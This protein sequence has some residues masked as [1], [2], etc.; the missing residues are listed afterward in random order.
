MTKLTA[1]IARDGRE[2]T[3]AYEF[4]ARSFPPDYFAARRHFEFLLANEP[5]APPRNHFIVRSS[6]GEIIGVQR[7][8][9]R[10]LALDDVEFSVCGISAGAVHPDYWHLGVAPAFHRALFDR[11]D[12]EYDLA[13]GFVRKKLDGYWAR[14]GYVGYT[15]FCAVT[16]MS[17]D[18][19]CP[20]R[21]RELRPFRPQDLNAC[22]AHYAHTHAS[23]LGTMKRDE[24]L[25][26]FARAK[27]ERFNLGEHLVL[28]GPGGASLG[29]AIVKGDTVLEVAAGQSHLEELVCALFVSRRSDSLTFQ[30][31][32]LHPLFEILLRFN[33]SYG[34]R[35]VW[36]GGHVARVARV[37]QFLDR[38]KPAL[39]KRVSEVGVA[40]FDLQMT[41]HRFQWDRSDLVITASEKQNDN[42][43]VVF[44]P[45]EWHKALL[46]VVPV[47]ALRGFRSNSERSTQ[48]A[49]LL[50]PQLW[51]QTPEL[52]QF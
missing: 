35:R 7:T 38:L 4:L 25:W 43:N 6:S 48:I 28:E 45:H 11:I 23:V 34:V 51:P 20:P 52:D 44:E 17:R 16:V 30:L 22:A 1:S 10:T 18:I 31:S 21:S 46:G 5:Y 9:D 50:F 2:L 39:Q 33:H 29:Y 14:F 15:S 13:I 19:K 37:P 47:K 3:E 42:D 27:L 8:V 32:P 24:L 26:T 41:G 49:G 40:E 12:R 36:N